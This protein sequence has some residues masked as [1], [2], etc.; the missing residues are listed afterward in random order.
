MLRR[1]AR[2][3]SAVKKL[4][5]RRHSVQSYAGRGAGAHPRCAGSFPIAI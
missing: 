3:G 2:F 5:G 4:I 1:A